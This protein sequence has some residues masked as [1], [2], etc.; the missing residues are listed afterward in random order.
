MIRINLLPFRAARKRENVRQQVV[1]FLLVVLIA[2]GVLAYVTYYLNDK[3]STLQKEIEYTQKQVAHYNAIAK[4]AE[5]LKKELESLRRK[6]EVIKNLN[7]GRS[8]SFHI[9]DVLT[10]MV[11]EKRMWL[12]EI[13]SKDK[14]PPKSPTPPPGKPGAAA[15]PPE[16]PA[17]I[18][19]EIVVK[20][21]GVALD[22]KTVADFMTRLECQGMF[23]EVRLVTLQQEKIRQGNN[24]DDIN[25]KRFLVTCVAKP[26]PP[27]PVPEKK[28]AAGSATAPTTD[29]AQPK[30]TEKP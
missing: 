25:L 28:P 24:R 17:P 16:P 8:A 26:I 21:Q 18:T 14:E 7:R 23:S 5:K 10:D 29:N 22:N 4:E 13:E 6:L 15:P 12:T 9:F 20:I 3:I 2:G 1:V 19:I 30:G 11:I 27:E